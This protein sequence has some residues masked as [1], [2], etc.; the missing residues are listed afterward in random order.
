[1]GR[2]EDGEGAERAEASQSAVGK[3]G[4]RMTSLKDKVMKEKCKDT[5]IVFIKK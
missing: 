1:M 3:E 2:C 4:R 5:N